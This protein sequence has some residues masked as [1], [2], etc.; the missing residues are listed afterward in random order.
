[1]DLP[2]VAAVVA[3]KEWRVRVL[4]RSTMC[5]SKGVDSSNLGDVKCG[6]ELENEMDTVI[7]ALSPVAKK[8]S[9]LIS[10]EKTTVK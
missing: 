8:I 2:A 1:M 5:A 4:A 3:L 9:K 10:V 7:D 6:I